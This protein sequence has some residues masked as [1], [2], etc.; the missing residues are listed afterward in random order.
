ME[1]RAHALTQLL[2]GNAVSQQR[3]RVKELVEDAVQV[4]SDCTEWT[5]ASMI[6]PEDL[7][8]LEHD[9]LH[10]FCAWLV[11]SVTAVLHHDRPGLACMVEEL[12]KRR[13]RVQDVVSLAQ[14]E[15]RFAQLLSP[16]TRSANVESQ[17]ANFESQS[18]NFESQ[19]A[20][21]ESQSA[22]FESQSAQFEN[23]ESQSKAF[24]HSVRDLQRKGQ[25]CPTLYELCHFLL[26]QLGDKLVHLPTSDVG[27]RCYKCDEVHD[28]APNT[29]GACQ[30][31]SSDS[32]E[33]Q[34]TR[35]LPSPA[36]R[37]AAAQLGNLHVEQHSATLHIAF[38]DT[39]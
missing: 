33:R 1:E 4:L 36:V 14:S 11:A 8:H 6:S 10:S 3:C 28:A 34:A 38:A 9:V 32:A 27:D 18:A 17:S 13:R 30:V 5:D 7:E 22:N 15:T 26:F 35:E 25:L 21:F 24:A 37:L 39:A 19:S 31:S 29:A 20:N 23:S 2:R 16:L 12:E